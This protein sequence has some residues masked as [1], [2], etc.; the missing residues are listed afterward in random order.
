MF[1]DASRQAGALPEPARSLAG[2]VNDRNVVALGRRLLPF[3]EELGG[4]PALSPD[5]SPAVHVPV[6]LLHGSGDNVIPSSETPLLAEY[7]R[8]QG[9]AQV[10]WLLTPLVSHANITGAAP[11]EAWRL[12]RFW[13]EVLTR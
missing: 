11:A 6:F 13:K 12:V 1:A 5:R 7:L 3:V 10:R 9:N 2:L 4:D 8:Q